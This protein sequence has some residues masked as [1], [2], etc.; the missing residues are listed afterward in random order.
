MLSASP[1]VLGTVYIE[2]DLG[3][4]QHADRFEVT[5]SGGA[6]GTELTRLI[7]NGDQNTPGFSVGDIFFDTE[8]TGLGADSPAGFTI[9]ELISDNPAASVTATVADGTSLLVLD[10][11]GFRAG[12]R[13]IFS[14][15]VDEV[16]FLDPAQTDLV[17]I[18]DG[19]DP[20]TSGVE[21]QGSQLT[22]FFSAPHYQP[23]SGEGVF[24][25]RY[26]DQLQASKL[27]LPPDNA[28]NLR[29]RTTGAFLNTQQ[30]IDP[31]SISGYVYA[32]HSN[33]GIRDADEPGLGGVTVHVI[34][35]DT[36]EQQQAITVTTDANGFYQ[37][38]DLSPGT[39][40][41]VEVTQP[42][43]YLDGLDTAGTV[44]GEVQGMAINPGDNLE[45]IFLAGGTQ[46]I[47]YNF[48]EILP[49]SISGKVH[50]SDRYGT[51]FVT[52]TTTEPLAGVTI[53][54]LDQ[55]DNVIGES[56]TDTAG[57]YAFQG[58]LPGLYSVVEFTPRRTD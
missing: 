3:S 46:G 8:P 32:D 11:Q 43:N 39:Y 29:D 36:I 37:A 18:N 20:I 53:H 35:V 33:D 48:G 57:E 6:E 52:G 22:A 28:N 51:C 27:D 1:L 55:F 40:R 9:E 13:L 47:E 19:F 54:L 45:G 12:D 50:L 26:D 58:L 14:V 34:P 44:D 17:E 21:F 5:F 49:A 23:A 4:D 15:D 10:F 7:L 2:E 42:A 25:N 31:A 56:V 38:L 24:W 41:V 30:L 16:E